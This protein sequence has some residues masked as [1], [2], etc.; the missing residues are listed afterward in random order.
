LT[1]SKAATPTKKSALL[2]DM[3]GVLVDVSQSY[4]KAIQETVQFFAGKKATIQ[5]IQGFKEQGGYNN[6]W[7]LTEAVLQKRGITVPKTEIIQKFQELY[8]GNGKKG[9][10]ENEKWLLPKD[11]L[12]KL[13]KHF[14]TGIVTGRPRQ[15]TFYVLQK[16]GV[17]ELFDA[18]VVMEDYPAEKAKPDPL[19][20]TL[21]LKK[22]GVNVERAIYVGDSVDDIVA[23][24]RAAVTPFGCLPPGVTRASLKEKLL[25]CGAE[26]VFNNV[27]EVAELCCLTTK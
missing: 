3:D 21:A 19:P 26:K 2:F 13:H 12:S 17:V 4:R 23:S 16:F 18:V 24:K 5:E 1:N 14:L 9:L 15:E 7:D 25:Q 27:A 22:L 11:Q 6:D 20:I 10:I 8:L